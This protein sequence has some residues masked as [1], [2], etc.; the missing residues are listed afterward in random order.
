MNYGEEY[1]CWYLRL[2]GFFP[3]QNFVIHKSSQVTHSSDCDILA[4]R[5]PYVYEEIGGKQKDWD[6]L[7]INKLNFKCTIGVVCEVK[8]GNYDLNIFKP[9][10]LRHSVGRLGFVDKAKI[11]KV[12]HELETSP[13]VDVNNQY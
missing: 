13:I 1:A 12:T 11:D 10:Y 8:T 4:V 5:P 7:L 3:I 9:E 2:N 6:G